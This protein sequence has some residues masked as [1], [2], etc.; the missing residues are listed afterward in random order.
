MTVMMKKDKIM[1][2]KGKQREEY[3]EEINALKK[4]KSKER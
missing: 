4:T 2:K 3:E 1:N